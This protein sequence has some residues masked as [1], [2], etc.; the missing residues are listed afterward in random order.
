MRVTPGDRAA[1]AHSAGKPLL[2]EEYGAQKQYITP[3]D[4][5]IHRCLS[6]IVSCRSAVTITA[7]E[8]HNC[9]T[10]LCVLAQYVCVLTTAILRSGKRA[11]RG[12]CHQNPRQPDA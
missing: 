11:G 6:A 9:T 3:R 7:H 8:G 4:A 10:V 5:L 1:L 12:S 2:M